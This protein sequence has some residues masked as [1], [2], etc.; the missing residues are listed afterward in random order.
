MK[1]NQIWNPNPNFGFG[2][3]NENNN[4]IL[5]IFQCYKYVMYVRFVNGW[6]IMMY[7][8]KTLVLI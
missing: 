6:S 5:N 2:T 8:F 1:N 7:N 3:R 4:I